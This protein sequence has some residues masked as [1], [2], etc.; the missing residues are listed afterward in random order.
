LDGSPAISNSL[1]AQGS[2]LILTAGST[3]W[4]YTYNSKHQVE[5]EQLNLDGTSFVLNPEYDSLGNTSSLTY[6][7]QFT[8]TYTPNALGQPTVLNDGSVNVASNVL[9]DPNGQL[10]SFNYGN[11]LRFSQSLDTQ[12]RPYER[13]VLQGLTPLDMTTTI[14]S[15]R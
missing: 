14:T 4:T 8:A 11:G 5:T 10:K 13:A 12:F 9:Y 15:M 6:K 3:S 7:G 2:L 1:D